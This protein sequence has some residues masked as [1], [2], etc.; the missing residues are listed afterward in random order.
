M[1]RKLY[2]ASL[3]RDPLIRPALTYANN[4]TPQEVGIP[5]EYGCVIWLAF[6]LLSPH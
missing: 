3:Y 1:Q 5:D 6:N 4:V 2:L